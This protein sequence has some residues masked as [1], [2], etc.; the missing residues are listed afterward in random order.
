MHR[1]RPR[2][3]GERARERERREKRMAGLE[4]EWNIDDEGVVHRDRAFWKNYARQVFFFGVRTCLRMFGPAGELQVSIGIS[5][6]IYQVT[7]YS[8]KHSSI[9]Q[10]NKSSISSTRRRST[11]IASFYVGLS[12]Q[13]HHISHASP[14]AGAGNRNETQM[15][16]KWYVSFGVNQ[17]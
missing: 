8:N 11:N 2:R 9:Q 1:C 7:I 10:Y 3:L 17:M 6:P 13:F 5:F 4:A 16:W 15:W 12:Y 14:A